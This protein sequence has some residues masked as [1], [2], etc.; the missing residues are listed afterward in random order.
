[1][2]FV[3]AM[4]LLAAFCNMLAAIVIDVPFARLCYALAAVMFVAAAVLHLVGG[5]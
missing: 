1:M 3:V 2:T 5:Q 4:N